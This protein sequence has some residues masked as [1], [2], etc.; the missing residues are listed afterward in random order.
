MFSEIKA[1]FILS[2]IRG[3]PDEWFGISYSMNVYRGCMHACI[4][5]DTRSTCYGIGDLSDIRVK[6]NAPELLSKE[7][8]AKKQKATIGT[9]SMNDPY[10]PVEKKLG[11]FRKC[12]EIINAYRF[13]VHVMTK[14]NLVTRDTDILKEAGK[15]Y[16]AASFSIT[17]ASDTLSKKLEPGASVT[18]ERFKALEYLSKHGI[19]CGVLMMPVLPFINDTEENIRELF[20]K[21]AGSGA[22]YI[23]PWFGL[24]QREG[25]RE[26]F[27]KQLDH[28]FPGIKEKYQQQFGLSYGCHSPV[29]KDL[30]Q[31][32]AELS[33]KYSIPLKMKHYKPTISGKQES[34]F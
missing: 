33:E 21:A 22:S 14:S 31:L 20:S 25:Q 6:I 7:L 32:S 34:L 28:H 2:K 19:Y 23:L 13:P 30:Y 4:Y 29:S 12:L 16:A 9:G 18:S 27:H 26:Y 1:R 3:G 24:T 10:M 17:C 5:C 15:V 8:R 11:I